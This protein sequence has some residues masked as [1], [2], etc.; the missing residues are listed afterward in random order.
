MADSWEG[1]AGSK[2]AEIT[3]SCQA[4]SLDFVSSLQPSVTLLVIVKIL[5]ILLLKVQF[6]NQLYQ[7]HLG[8]C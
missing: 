6:M 2:W 3:S 1:T 4:V 7:H 5:H 8:A